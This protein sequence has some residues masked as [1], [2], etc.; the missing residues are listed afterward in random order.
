MIVLLL[1]SCIL[2]SGCLQTRI[3]TG[4]EASNQKAEIM[5][6]HGFVVGLVP[7]VNAPL[8]TQDKCGEAGVSEVYF[9]Q[10]F[11]QG[12]AEAITQNIYS[13]Q[14]FTATCAS[15]GGMATAPLPPSY[16]LRD[17]QSSGPDGTSVRPNA[18]STQRHAPSAS[19]RK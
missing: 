17:K 4:K 5:W 7:P 3:T 10:T 16:F 11:V 19:K 6:A 18:A 12:L 9:R 14:R 15:G 1:G 2:F 8:N 13:P